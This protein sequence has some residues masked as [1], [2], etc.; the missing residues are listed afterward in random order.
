MYSDINV[1]YDAHNTQMQMAC[2]TFHYGLLSR[3]SPHVGRE[4]I[5]GDFG[6]SLLNKRLHFSMVKPTRQRC[7]HTADILVEAEYTCTPFSWM[8]FD[9]DGDGRKILGRLEQIQTYWY[10]FIHRLPCREFKS[11]VVFLVFSKGQ[12]IVLQRRSSRQNGLNII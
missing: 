10:A 7:G 12:R 6:S 9:N 5:A 2:T 1:D 3:S 8:H 4:G 11:L